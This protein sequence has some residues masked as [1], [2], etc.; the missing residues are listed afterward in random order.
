MDQLVEILLN[1]SGPMPYVLVFLVL[2]ICGMGLPVP[3]DIVLFAAGVTCFYGE[4]NVWLMISICLAGVLVGD[5]IMFT[6]GFV[7]GKR[8]TKLPGF[9]KVLPPHRLEKVKRRLRKDGNKV[10]FAARFMPGLR[11]PIFFT[12][13]MLHL[14]FRIFLFYDGTAALISVPAIVYLVYHFGDKL[15]WVLGKIKEVQFGVVAV[16]AL[17]L[18]FV[19]YKIYHEIKKADS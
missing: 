18:L 10:I 14:P 11:S 3:E 4:A 16:V 1:F 9:Q 13:G 19:G 12:A 7:Y 8:I 2:L 15:D 5:G 6:L 17:V